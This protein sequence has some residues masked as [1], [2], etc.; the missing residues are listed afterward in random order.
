[1]HRDERWRRF[2]I[3]F[4]HLARSWRVQS[5]FVVFYFTYY[6]YFNFAP[7]LFSIPVHAPDVSVLISSALL[8][9]HAVNVNRILLEDLI[10]EKQING[11][12]NH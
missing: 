12:R 2:L 9:T 8:S 6:I 1:M 3:Y 5:K 7:H 11:K 10:Q 4:D